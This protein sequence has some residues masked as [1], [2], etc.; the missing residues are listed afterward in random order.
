MSTLQSFEQ[1]W[2]APAQLVLLAFGLMNAGVP[3]SAVG[4]IS[5]V[6]AMSLVIG[7]PIGVVGTTLIAELIGFRRSA[8]LDYRS[9]VT[10]GVA[11][12]IGFTVAL[13]FVSASNLPSPAFEQA[14]MGALFSFGAG[15]VAIAVGRALGLRP[16]P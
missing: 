14:K 11:A 7:K 15:F 5:W 9:L 4:P 12:G 3:F 13:F 8:G 2:K 6:V 16:T 1:W 10:L